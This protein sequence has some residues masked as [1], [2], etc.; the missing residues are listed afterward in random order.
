M[1][2]DL[3][4]VPYCTGAADYADEHAHRKIGAQ[5]REHDL[6]EGHDAQQRARNAGHYLS[7]HEVV[8]PPLDEIGQAAAHYAEH[9]ALDYEGAAYEAVGGADHLHYRYL[10]AASEGRELYRVRHDEEGHDD[11]DNDEDE[12]YNAYDVSRRDEGLRVVKMGVHLGD[13]VHRLKVGLGLAHEADV[14]Q[15]D[16]VPVTEHGGVKDVEKLGVIILLEVLHGFLVG[17]E[18]NAG[19]V[20]HGLDQRLERLGLVER[21]RVVYEGDD[22]VLRLKAGYHVVDIHDQQPEA[23]HDDEAGHDYRDGGKA[24]KSVAEYAGE[25]G[26]YQ[27]SKSI[28]S[29]STRPFRRL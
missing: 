5:Q 23:A 10:L 26:F 28:H 9:K 14:S 13:A 20:G 27:I 15:M 7:G 17:D 24:H 11:E 2:S 25:A 19:Y 4:V 6:G 21:Q 18:F 12:R 8:K 1:R 3:Q 16:D 22:L 29:C